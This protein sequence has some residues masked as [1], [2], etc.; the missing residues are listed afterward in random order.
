MS[1]LV[2]DFLRTHSIAHLAATHA[3]KARIVGHKASSN[4]D[5]IEARESDVLAQ[6]CRGLV[7]RTAHKDEAPHARPS[8]AR[9]P[10]PSSG[11]VLARRMERATAIESSCVL[12]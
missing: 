10:P 6:Q 8:S 11:L 4:Y 2:Q 12:D 7:L 3:V 5:Q 1:L 9:R